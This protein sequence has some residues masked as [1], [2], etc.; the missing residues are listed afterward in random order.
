MVVETMY[1]SMLEN[2]HGLLGG[3]IYVNDEVVGRFVLDDSGYVFPVSNIPIAQNNKYEIEFNYESDLDRNTGSEKYRLDEVSLYI[4]FSGKYGRWARTK[5][6]VRS[7]AIEFM[8]K[9]VYLRVNLTAIVEDPPQQ[10]DSTYISRL[11]FDPSPAV[12]SSDVTATL[13]EAPNILTVSVLHN[14]EIIQNAKITLIPKGE[15]LISVTGA[16]NNLLQN[17]KITLEA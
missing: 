14:S 9:D 17:A 11:A 12:V 16:D 10:H 15:L 8:P 6:Y 5:P 4:E 7:D 1:F 2:P 13:Q 3:A